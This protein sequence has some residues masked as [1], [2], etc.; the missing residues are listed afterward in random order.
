MAA[1]LRKG[2]EKMKIKIKITEKLVRRVSIDAED[3]AEAKRKAEDMYMNE[4]IVLTADDFAG[5]TITKG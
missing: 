4:E 3:T 1:L 5:Y 2:I